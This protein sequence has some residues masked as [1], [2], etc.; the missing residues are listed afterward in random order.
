M[1]PP[2][3]FEIARNEFIAVTQKNR[4][5]FIDFPEWADRI[6]FRSM[7]YIPGDSIPPVP[8]GITIT[9]P[10]ANSNWKKGVQTTISFTYQNVDSVLFLFSTD[11]M[12][13]WINLL[14]GD[15]ASPVS[16]NSFAF[17]PADYFKQPTGVLIIKDKFSST[18]DTSEYFSLEMANGLAE[19]FGLNQV[20]V[21]PNPT[22]DIINVE[23]NKSKV[24]NVAILDL[25][26]REILSTSATIINLDFLSAGT[27][28]IRI[29]INSSY[30]T[31]KFFKH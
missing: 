26:G 9:A 15:I 29:G 12:K 17:T 6:N 28:F 3:A 25:Q 14:T 13:T 30:V 20:N 16:N 21:Y 2:D 8:K 10:T 1:D 18:A 23:A 4:N 24:E 31:K 7:T 5:P 19:G 22:H 11:S 27:Y